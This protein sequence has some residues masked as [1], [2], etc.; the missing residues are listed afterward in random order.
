MAPPP[1][2]APPLSPP[3]AV[4]LALTPLGLRP[5]PP[6][7]VHHL[8]AERRH[9]YRRP[10]LRREPLPP[11]AQQAG[12]PEQ[13]EGVSGARPGVGD[14]GGAARPLHGR[15]QHP[16]PPAS[17]RPHLWKWLTGQEQ[18]PEDLNSNLVFTAIKSK[19]TDN[20]TKHASP[21]SRSTPGQP[22]VRGWDNIK[23]DEDAPKYG[24]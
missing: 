16:P 7:C 19:V 18:L 2:A 13:A 11:P 12:V 24:N 20:L 21:E 9:H 1:R 10:L 3:V 22:W 14:L 15:V 23:K 4:S 8:P 17:A 6:L 5:P